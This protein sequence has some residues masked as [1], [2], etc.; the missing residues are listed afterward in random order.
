[1]NINELLSELDLA[2]DQARS[3]QTA[4]AI[5]TAHDHLLAIAKAAKAHHEASMELAYDGK[6]T[7]HV[8]TQHAL[9]LTIINLGYM[10]LEQ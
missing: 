1:M 2:C 3:I 5:L 9:N 7:R 8:E 4:D 6:S 10:E